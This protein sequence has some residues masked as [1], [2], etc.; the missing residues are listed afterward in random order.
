MQQHKK[1]NIAIIDDHQI[2]IDGITALLKGEHNIRIAYATTSP[3]DLLNQLPQQDV[4]VLITDYMMPEM[5]GLELSKEVKKQYPSIKILALSMNGKGDLVSNMIDEADIDGYVLKNIG[6]KELLEAI[7]K[8]ANGGQYFPDEI[9]GELE[10]VHIIKKENIDAHLTT[11]EIEIIRLIEKE[12]SNKQIAEHLFISERTV[13]THRKNIF[14]KT[15]TN[16]VLGLIK[17]AYQH[18]L[19]GS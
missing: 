10:K 17:Y 7:E 13:E 18:A 11:R 2:V 14:R 4:D 19:I 5:N 9:I 3:I 6:K 1:I 16:S 8:I 15:S 12:C